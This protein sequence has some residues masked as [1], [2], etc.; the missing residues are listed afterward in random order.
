F[1]EKLIK[2]VVD[3]AS[4]HKRKKVKKFLEEN[5]R[6]ELTYLPPYSPELNPI[7]KFWNI[8]KHSLTK[9]RYYKRL[10]DLNFEIRRF[11]TISN[12]NKEMVMSRVGLLKQ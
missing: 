2:M 4:W 3:N 9:N 12:E 11:G 5:P 7:E 8:L 6:I 10:K 1:P